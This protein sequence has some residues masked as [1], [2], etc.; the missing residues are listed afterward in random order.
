VEI[1]F[2]ECC[3]L[4]CNLIEEQRS[5]VSTLSELKFSFLRSH[6]KQKSYS[7]SC[8]WSIARSPVTSPLCPQRSGSMLRV[9]GVLGAFGALNPASGEEL[10]TLTDRPTDWLT[11]GRGP[12]CDGWLSSQWQPYDELPLLNDSTLAER[13]RRGIV[14]RRQSRVGDRE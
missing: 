2:L 1:D 3:I 11:G 4:R 14:F 13:Y 6:R 12:S 10:P 7:V 5:S 9:S 8:N